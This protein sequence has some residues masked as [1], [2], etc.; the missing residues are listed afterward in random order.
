ME[1]LWCLS[2]SHWVL[3]LY[4]FPSLHHPLEHARPCLR[5]CI[6]QVRQLARLLF[7]LFPHQTQGTTWQFATCTSRTY[8]FCVF[9]WVSKSHGKQ[10]K[11]WKMISSNLQ[12]VLLHVN[13]FHP[14]VFDPKPMRHHSDI[15]PTPVLRSSTRSHVR[16]QIGMPSLKK[17]PLLT[18]C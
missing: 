18:I 15:G 11:M 4:N 7:E 6:L 17:T 16:D 1:W 3:L 9:S 14:E 5:T 2:I 13:P 12:S 8:I 10:Q